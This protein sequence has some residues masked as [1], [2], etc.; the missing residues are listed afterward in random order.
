MAME[1]VGPRQRPKLQFL[2]ESQKGQ[3]C[4]FNL[5]L[6]SCCRD[7]FSTK[8]GRPR[9]ILLLFRFFLITGGAQDAYTVSGR[10]IR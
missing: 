3:I 4:L 2:L 5:N 8:L 7:F 1:Q 9:Q 6:A 10:K